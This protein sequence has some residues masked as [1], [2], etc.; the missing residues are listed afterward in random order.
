MVNKIDTSEGNVASGGNFVGRDATQ[1]PNEE[2]NQG[3]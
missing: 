1:K 3:S 2:D